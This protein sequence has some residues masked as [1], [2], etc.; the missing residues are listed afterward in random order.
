MNR[1]IVIA[2]AMLG[3]SAVLLGAFGAHA[4]RGVV[5]PQGAGWWQTA[6]QYQLAHALALLAIAPLPLRRAALAA[7]CMTT[8]TT[9]FA[10]TLYAMAL[11][12]PHWLGAITPV[13]G[14]LM[15]AGWAV[16]GWDAWRGAP[17][18]KSEDR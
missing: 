12:L 9:I 10:A 13:G 11:G 17:V 16:L 18:R 5:T 4:L 7:W 14:V 2:A 1:A 6:V 8:G 3:G 15:I